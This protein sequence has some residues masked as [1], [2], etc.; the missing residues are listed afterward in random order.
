MALAFG[1]LNVLGFE[2]WF[3]KGCGPDRCFSSV[4]EVDAKFPRQKSDSIS[5][6]F[7]DGNLVVLHL[8]CIIARQIL[9]SPNFQHENMATGTPHFHDENLAEFHVWCAMTHRQGFASM[10]TARINMLAL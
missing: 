7:R 5:P 4:F 1:A 6:H 10:Y 8:N 9:F 2:V 3:Q